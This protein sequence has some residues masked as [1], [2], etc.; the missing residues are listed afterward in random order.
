MEALLE[1]YVT[2]DELK[3]Y[4]QKYE[5]ER[6]ANSSGVADCQT[7]FEYA[8]ALIRSRY[9]TDILRG[10]HE[11]EDLCSTGEPNA[12]RDYLFYLALANTKLKVFYSY[13]K[14]LIKFSISI[15]YTQ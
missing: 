6:R 4:W 5:N 9:T 15:C 3:K 8:L 2:P 11:F 13:Y 14:L 12:R 7:R 1:D 10:V